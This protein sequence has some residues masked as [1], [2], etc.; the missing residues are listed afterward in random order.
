MAPI[1]KTAL[2][3]ARTARPS[4]A[5]SSYERVPSKNDGRDR[6]GRTGEYQ[7]HA[8]ADIHPAHSALGT[9]KRAPE[10]AMLAAE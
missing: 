4:P 8:H 6:A 2:P 3:T 9:R 7:E 10:V 1:S 5:S